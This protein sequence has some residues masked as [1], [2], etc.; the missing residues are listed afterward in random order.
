[1]QVKR[2][3]TLNEKTLEQDAQVL[4]RD[5]KFINIFMLLETIMQGQYILVHLWGIGRMLYIH[6]YKLSKLF[7]QAAIN[8]WNHWR[9]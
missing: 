4:W 8:N 9:I 5:L 7:R 6:I 3:I 2:T 1:M